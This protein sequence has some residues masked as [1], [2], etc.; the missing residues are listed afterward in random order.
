MELLQLRYFITVARTLNISKA[1]QYHMIPQPAMSQT[2][3]R[4]EKELGKPLFDRHR[5]KLTLTKD[6]Q[7][8]LHSI[9][10]S[11]TEMDLAVEKMH[12]EDNVLHGELTLLVRQFRSATV[13]CIVAFWKKYPEVSFRIFLTPED[14][15]LHNY[16][17]CI[18]CTPPSEQYSVGIPL[19]TEKLPL[20][21]SAD[22]FLADKATVSFEE[23]Q[24][25]K[26]ALLDKSRTQISDL[27]RQHGFEPNISM[28]CE[29]LYCLTKLISSGMVIALG[30]K[31]TLRGISN[32]LVAVP[33]VPEVT[34]TTYVFEN[35]RKIS[36]RLR[37]TF[38]DFLIEF[39]SQL[40]QVQFPH[41]QD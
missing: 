18:S 33:T 40:Q 2:I 9:T 7:A 13:D 19:I 14:R 37:Q 34:R 26:F 24:N 36:N 35:S 21:V 6:G 28:V 29:D 20:L 5:N 23:L 39:F 15:D 11:I 25:V 38:L 16:D 4:L 12:S 1:A 22:H 10:A 8:F 41:L 30:S 32:N 17:F 31:L 3:S 27:C